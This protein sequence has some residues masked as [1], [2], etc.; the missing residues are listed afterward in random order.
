M[1]M[2]RAGGHNESALPASKL[3]LKPFLAVGI[4]LLHRAHVV[5]VAS[6][7]AARLAEVFPG[8][9]DRDA[10]TCSVGGADE[11]IGP[12]I[13]LQIVGVAAGITGRRRRSKKIERRLVL[14]VVAIHGD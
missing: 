6:G 4:Q 12:D 11:N 2:P 5:G 14:M 8:K 13:G 1:T 10:S 7:E 9:V 3:V